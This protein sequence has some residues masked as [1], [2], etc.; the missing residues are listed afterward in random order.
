MCTYGDKNLADYMWTTWEKSIQN[1]GIDFG[2]EISTELQTRMLMVILE[3]KNSKE[4][5][6]WHTR[7]LQVHNTKNARIWQARQ[8]VLDFLIEAM[9]FDNPDDIF[10]IEGYIKP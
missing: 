10:K 7:K 3:P 9:T 2:Q 4:I 6:D 5:L 1:I 8:H